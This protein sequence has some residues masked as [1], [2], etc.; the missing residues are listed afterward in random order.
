MKGFKGRK[1]EDKPLPNFKDVYDRIPAEQIYAF[2]IPGVVLNSTMSSPL[3]DK[4]NVSSFSIFWSYRKNK[5]L[6]KD[7]RYG[8]FGDAIDF[9]QRLF[10][11]TS[12]VEACMK[13]F[14]DFGIDDFYIFKE[15]TTTINPGNSKI[16][17][18]SKTKRKSKLQIT[19]RD[20]NQN[21]I[22]FWGQYGITTK[23][24]KY[25]NIYPIKYFYIDGNIKI[26]DKLAYAYVENKDGNITYKIYQPLIKIGKKWLSNNDSSVWELW[27]MLPK[28]HDYLIIT[29]SRKDALSI[30]ATMNIPATSL[31]AEGTI[32]KDNVIDELK[33]RFKYIF[34]F[35]DNDFDKKTNYG[36]EYGRKLSELFDL[37]QIEI[38]EIHQEKD[39]SDLVKNKG[40]KYARTVLWQLIKKELL[41]HLIERK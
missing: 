12:Q 35:Y 34:L 37:P 39:Y 32:P 29:K 16:S 9:V 6:W 24:L 2:Y 41:K 8:W 38:H 22:S 27:H 14:N 28:T 5:Y 20:W 15:L 23:W 18:K 17:V 31:Q 33:Q 11:Y 3:G 10:G 4:D 36:R 25:A 30:M 13:I 21:D 40:I 19:I 26:A 1:L 7:F